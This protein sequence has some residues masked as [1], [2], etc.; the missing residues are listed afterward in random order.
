V[1]DSRVDASDIT[2]E[3][4]DGIVKLDGA[5][6]S[7]VA[8][9]AAVA[10]AEVVAGVTDVVNAMRVFIPESNLLPTDADIKVSLGNMLAANPDLDPS[11][12]SVMVMDGRVD[13]EGS[14]DA[15]WKK[16]FVEELVAIHKGVE[17]VRSS[18]TV[19]PTKD[20]ADQATADDIFGALQRHAMIDADRVTVRV[21]D[22]FVLLSGSVPTTMARHAAASIASCTFGVVDVRDELD[23]V[24]LEA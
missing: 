15:H 8:R 2:V 7:A 19:V 17:D 11:R 3:V 13:L 18:L 4:S 12:I 24:P 6:P 9:S 14:V 21:E 20:A 22:G 5:V 16:S 1:W 10:D 23:V